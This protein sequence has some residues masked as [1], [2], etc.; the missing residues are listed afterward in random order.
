MQLDLMNKYRYIYA[1]CDSFGQDNGTVSEHGNRKNHFSFI[2][3]H[4]HDT[5]M[6]M[7]VFDFVIITIKPLIVHQ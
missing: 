3:T 1:P 4:T 2:G 6:T 7:R 5:I